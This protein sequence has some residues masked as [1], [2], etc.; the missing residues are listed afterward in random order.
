MRLNNIYMSRHTQK[1]C[2]K[3][4]TLR[5]GYVRKYKTLLRSKGYTRIIKGKKTRIF[6]SS[7][8]TRVKSTCV[9]QIGFSNKQIGPLRKGELIKHGYQYRLP[10][11]KRH[12]ALKDAIKEFG[13]L[14]SYRKLD[15]VAKLG[16]RSS[17]R[18]SKIFAEDRNWIR[19]HYLQ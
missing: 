16:V 5:K 18:A 11:E 2:K 19:S 4:Y 1:Q 14:S 7:K 17:P 15:A 12:A 3:G 9:K 6:P 13:A 10:T 8:P